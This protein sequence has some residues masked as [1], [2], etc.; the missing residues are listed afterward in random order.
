VP[1]LA[2]VPQYLNCSLFFWHDEGAGFQNFASNY[3]AQKTSHEFRFRFHDLRHKFAVDYLRRGGNI[4]DL[5]KILGHS[6]VKT[7][8]FYLDYL[9][10]EEQKVAKF[11]PGFLPLAARLA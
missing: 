1:L 3:A 11:G 2:A 8:E 6:S 10:L 5:Q 7:T 4:Y 9:D